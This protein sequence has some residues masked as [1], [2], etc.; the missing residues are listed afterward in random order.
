MECSWR[1]PAPPRLHCASRS[2]PQP[3]THPSSKPTLAAG[4]V[5]L[6]QPLLLCQKLLQDGKVAGGNGARSSGRWGIAAVVTAGST[7][8]HLQRK[9]R[10]RHRRR[11]IHGFDKSFTGRVKQ[12][13][14]VSELVATCSR[15]WEISAG[16]HHIAREWL[17]TCAP[18]CLQ[19]HASNVQARE[20]AQQQQQ[21]QM[22]LPA[23]QPRGEQ[24][25]QHV[26][27]AA[28]TAAATART[29]FVR[30]VTQFPLTCTRL[31][32]L[33]R[34]QLRKERRLKVLLVTGHVGASLQVC[35]NVTIV[36]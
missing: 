27:D 18:L 26:G 13:M 12:G 3:T 8:L 22:E 19:G 11:F 36:V 5:L 25:Q 15:V 7:M 9:E 35:S 2:V 23:A 14:R 29:G 10:Q 16:K 32:H 28:G 6:I 21:Q 24:Q 4:T 1:W 30:M 20:A 31:P 34:R 17:A 33:S